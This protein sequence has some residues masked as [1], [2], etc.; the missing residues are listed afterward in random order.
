MVGVRC[1]LEKSAV[2]RRRWKL[3]Q[4]METDS[5]DFERLVK[6]RQLIA[7]MSHRTT[8]QE[9]VEHVLGATVNR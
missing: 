3:T 1:L 2:E 8:R 7:V 4:E 5:F 9:F 6:N